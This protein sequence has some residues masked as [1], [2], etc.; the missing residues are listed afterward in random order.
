MLYLR[1]FIFRES[2]EGH[3]GKERA[4]GPFFSPINSGV[5]NYICIIMQKSISKSKS[6]SNIP[7]SNI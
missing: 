5:S 1:S 6:K 4:I 3:G 7:I 2:K